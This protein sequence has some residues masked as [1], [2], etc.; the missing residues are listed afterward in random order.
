MRVAVCYDAHEGHENSGYE[1]YRF[2]LEELGHKCPPAFNVA[3]GNSMRDLID[4][5]PDVAIQFDCCDIYSL[6]RIENC[7]SVWY[8]FD[9]W[10]NYTNNRE[11]NYVAD[12]N[13]CRMSHYVARAKTADIVFSMSTLGVENYRLN[14]VESLYLPIGGDERLARKPIPSAE[15]KIWIATLATEWKMGHLD[16]RR[17]NLI[18][19]IHEHFEAKN[20]RDK[21]YMTQSDYY[22]QSEIYNNSKIGWNYSPCGFSPLNFRNFEVMI[23]GSCLMLNQNSATQLINL[24]FVDGE[25]FVS[26][27]DDE[28]KMLE[29]IDWLLANDEHREAIALSGYNKTMRHHTMRH[30]CKIICDVAQMWKQ[31]RGIV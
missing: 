25:D 18:G 14:H 7:V 26:Y 29:I 16:N 9:N 22:K 17:G 11:L 1:G 30:R 8:A 12:G 10:Q 24:G 2:A 4:Y 3:N 27:P 5:H 20:Q 31:E 6:P 15:K 23:S 21:C 19:K 28:V 13:F